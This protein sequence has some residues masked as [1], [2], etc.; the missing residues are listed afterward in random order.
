MRLSL[1]MVLSMCTLIHLAGMSLQ[2]ILAGLLESAR[3]TSGI[4]PSCTAVAVGV[5]SLIH[6]N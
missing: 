6:G 2:H 1:E 3:V 5:M 4:L